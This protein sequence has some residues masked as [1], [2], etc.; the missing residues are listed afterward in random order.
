MCNRKRK[1]GMVRSIHES[2]RQSISKTP[3]GLMQKSRNGGLLKWL[4]QIAFNPYNS[5]SVY[6]LF[7]WQRSARPRIT[8]NARNEGIEL[9]SLP[10]MH[11]PQDHTGGWTTAPPF[12]NN[13]KKMELSPNRLGSPP[14]HGRF[15]MNESCE[16][17]DWS[18]IIVSSISISSPVG[19]LVCSGNTAGGFS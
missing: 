3:S 5:G 6:G 1:E 19:F 11:D 10:V 15:P 13:A 4:I 8:I 16:V 2:S 17:T 14:S 7:L 12:Q 9:L 18:L